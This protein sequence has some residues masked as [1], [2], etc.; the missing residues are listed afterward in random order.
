MFDTSEDTVPVI[1][2]DQSLG[3]IRISI[4]G[5]DIVRI[6]AGIAWRYLLEGGSK[7]ESAETKPASRVRRRRS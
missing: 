3:W 6:E 7:T 1:D 4:G 5:V 2:T